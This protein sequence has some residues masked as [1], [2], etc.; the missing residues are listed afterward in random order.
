M[1]DLEGAF[2]NLRNTPYQVTS[3]E[4]VKYNCIAWAAG[5][6]NRWWWPT[7]HPTYYWPAPSLDNTLDGFVRILEELGYEKCDN[8]GPESGYDKVAIYVSNSLPAHMAR[9]LPNGQWT[10]KCG[11]CEDITHALEGLEG[12]YYG[13]VAQIMKRRQSP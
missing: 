6:D 5:V 8:P 13:S 3:A 1:S 7:S 4:D 11:R 9:Q 12:A 10:S 2:P